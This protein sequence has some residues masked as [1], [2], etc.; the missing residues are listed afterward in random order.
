[1]SSI[2]ATAEVGTLSLC[3]MPT[4][5]TFYGERNINPRG[6]SAAEYLVSWIS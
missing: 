1:M 6:E 2:T 5:T 4:H 3:V